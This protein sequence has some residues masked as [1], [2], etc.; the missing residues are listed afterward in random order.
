MRSEEIVAD[1]DAIPLRVLRLDDGAQIHAV[2]ALLGEVDQGP[3]M[4]Q[5]TLRITDD[6]YDRPGQHFRDRVDGVHDAELEGI[7]DDECPHRVDP[8]QVDE[9]LDDDRIHPATRI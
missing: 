1:T 5:V 9:R 3:W 8:G 6:A 7:E 4:Q 2:L